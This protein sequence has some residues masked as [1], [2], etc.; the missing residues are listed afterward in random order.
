MEIDGKKWSTVTNYIYS[1]MMKDD[2]PT[3]SNILQHTQTKDIQK[4]YEKLKDEK[5]LT[6]IRNALS[7]ALE[8]KFETSIKQDEDIIEKGSENSNP[9]QPTMTELLLSTGNRNIVYVGED[10]FLGTGKNNEGLNLLGKQLEQIRHQIELVYLRKNRELQEVT[11]NNSLYTAYLTELGLNNAIK[12]YFEKRDLDWETREEDYDL[13][14]FRDYSDLE[15]LKEELK[16]RGYIIKPMSFENFVSQIVENKLIPSTSILYIANDHPDA[17]VNTVRKKQL[18]NLKY[19]QEKRKRDI[20]FDMYVNYIIEKNYQ[21]I[22]HEKRAEAARQAFETLDFAEKTNMINRIWDLFRKSKLDSLLKDSI[23]IAISSIRIPD[24]SEIEQAETIDPIK[25]VQ[26]QKRDSPLPDTP[27]NKN[28][29]PVIINHQFVTQYPLTPEDAEQQLYTIFSPLDDGVLFKVN[30]N[31]YPTIYHCILIRLIESIPHITNAYNNIFQDNSFASIETIYS[32]YKKLQEDYETAFFKHYASLGLKIK[33]EEE[34]L[35]NLLLVTGSANLVWGDK[36]NSI[37]GKG[38]DNKGYNFVGKK[39]MEIRSDI[40]LDSERLKENIVYNKYD[41]VQI[42]HILSEPFI[43]RWM[44]MRI[45][46]MCKTV[47]IMMNYIKK[48]KEEEGVSDI[49]DFLDEYFVRIVLDN[50][51]KPCSSVFQSANS[52]ANKELPEYFKVAVR[53]CINFENANEDV[54][55]LFWSRIVS[56]IQTALQYTNGNINIIAQTIA[57]M[58]LLLSKP[59]RCDEFNTQDSCIYSALFNVLNGMFTFN[60]T[61]NLEVEGND[62]DIDTA[63]AIIL[64]RKET[65]TSN[66]YPRGLVHPP[67]QVETGNIK[68]YEKNEIEKEKF[69]EMKEEDRIHNLTGEE[70]KKEKNEVQMNQYNTLF[71]PE[72]NKQVGKSGH[73]IRPV[74]RTNKLVFIDGKWYEYKDETKTNT[75]DES[76]NKRQDERQDESDAESDAERQGTFIEK[77]EN[78]I[79]EEQDESATDEIIN[80]IKIFNKEIFDEEVRSN[81]KVAVKTIK[82][83]SLTTKQNKTNRINFFASLLRKQL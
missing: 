13:H 62:I 65:E 70:L 1:S 67:S 57:K 83:Y 45:K 53:G 23:D 20:V 7:D 25:G 78:P 15:E 6:T 72:V 46:D 68:D 60:K 81:I 71:Y 12:G 16:R 17:L 52:A 54:I 38:P 64:G 32:R 44:N 66:R 22:P 9:E 76:Q 31:T 61:I 80:M 63:V 77:L 14:R 30:D 27:E 35:K 19:R 50:I 75:Q 26:T 34:T 39:L 33:F 55:A 3:Y 74:G 24:E 8:A 59:K 37:L 10:N 41:I 56:M 42:K 18:R 47:N 5:Y 58:E 2:Q 51:Y 79:L 48:K 28:T 21:K 73:V 82:E 69:E 36:T 40:A 4:T 29:D 11:R 49:I 43:E